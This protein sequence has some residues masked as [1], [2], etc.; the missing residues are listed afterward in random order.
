MVAAWVDDDLDLDDAARRG[1]VAEGWSQAAVAGYSL[2]VTLM[3]IRQL[4]VTRIDALLRPHGLSFA[5]YEILMHLRLSTEPG[6]PVSVVGNALQVHPTSISNCLGQLI[7]VGFVTT[8]RPPNDR[9]VVLCVITRDGR[10]KVDRVTTLLNADIFERLGLSDE[11][12]GDLF[13][14]LRRYRANAGDF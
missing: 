11:Q 6:I 2:V 10:A 4:L 9:R 13:G 14:V 12:F 7:P 1:L 8:R 3:E 5:S